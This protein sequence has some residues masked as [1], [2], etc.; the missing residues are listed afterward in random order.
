MSVNSCGNFFF[1]LIRVTIILCFYYLAGFGPF[2]L[3]QVNTS[4][5]AVKV[6]HDAFK[7]SFYHTVYYSYT[8]I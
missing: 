4:W 6:H 7:C 1:L 2:G 8:Y 5:E 3:H